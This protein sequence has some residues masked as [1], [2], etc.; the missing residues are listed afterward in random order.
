MN[1]FDG[2]HEVLG[3]VESYYRV[4]QAGI[5][6]GLTKWIFTKLSDLEHHEH[7]VSNTAPRF[8]QNDGVELRHSPGLP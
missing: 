5:A 4:R 2:P 1:G 3:S 7:F 8:D 6:L